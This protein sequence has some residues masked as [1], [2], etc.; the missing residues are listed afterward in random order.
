[1]Q[2]YNLKGLHVFIAMPVRDEVHPH[3]VIALMDTM[4]LLREKGISHDFA[5]QIGGT[6]CGGRNAAVAGLLAGKANRL[7]FIDSDMI[8]KP[9]DVIRLL[10]MSTVMDI[11][12]AAYPTRSEPPTFFIRVQDGTKIPLNEHGCAAID[13]MGMGLSIIHRRV[14]EEM[15]AKAPLVRYMMQDPLPWVFK[16][17][18]HDGQFRGED[19]GFFED[20]R[21]LGYQCWL[22]PAISPGHV[23]QKT[24]SAQLPFTE[25]EDGKFLRVVNG[26][27]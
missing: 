21:K 9:E 2:S 11:V 16:F 12:V 7:L 10:A 1:M 19:V 27:H 23:G 17:E 13:G 3:T 4:A 6:L 14:L 20:A 8:W 26:V 22:D 24:F 5:F 15:S 25:S 18:V